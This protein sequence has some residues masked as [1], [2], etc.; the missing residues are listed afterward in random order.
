[1][2]LNNRLGKYLLRNVT[3]YD[4]NIGDLRYK[5]PA[6]QVRN[7]LGKNARLTFEEVENSRKFGSIAKKLRSGLLV[8]VQQ[9]VSMKLPKLTITQPEPILFP[10]ISKTSITLDV[11][12]IDENIL[13][14][15][16]MGEEDALLKELEQNSDI[17]D[18]PASTKKS[19]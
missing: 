18:L 4:I 7:L 12:Q 6:G 3:K 17:D 9:E 8:E 5:I 19:K 10:R 14:N 11:S 13:A 16:T 1:M 2:R 15:I